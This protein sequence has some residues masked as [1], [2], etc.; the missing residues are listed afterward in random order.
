VI[1][2]LVIENYRNSKTLCGG[3]YMLNERYQEYLQYKR[4]EVI[5]SMV[6]FL[7]RYNSSGKEVNNGDY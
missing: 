3:Y 6:R 7:W 4:D 2:F 5:F 1:T